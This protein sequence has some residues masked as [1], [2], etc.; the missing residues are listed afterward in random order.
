MPQPR[1]A[2][3]IFCKIHGS[4]LSLY[5]GKASSRVLTLLLRDR[6]TLN[7]FAL[8]LGRTGVKLRLIRGVLM[9]LVDRLR[10]SVARDKRLEVE[11]VTCASP[12]RLGESEVDGEGP[13]AECVQP[14]ISDLLRIDISLLLGSVARLSVLGPAVAA[15]AARTHRLAPRVSRNIRDAACFA[16]ARWSFEKALEAWSRMRRSTSVFSAARRNDGERAI[17]FRAARTGAS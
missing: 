6:A 9:P 10:A 5:D 3:F 11:V 2:P 16:W 12:P 15:A 13:V 17:D 4:S 7:R 8:G 14:R 1:I